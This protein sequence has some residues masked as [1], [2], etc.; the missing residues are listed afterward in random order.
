MLARK[1]VE[2]SPIAY[3]VDDAS[4]AVGIGQAKLWQLI[5][6]GKLAVVTLD[7]R[8][9]IMARDLEALLEEHRE[10]RGPVE[11]EGR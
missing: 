9:L 3:S 10:V 6:A 2:Y 8:T 4:V 11:G 5:S 1:K 7:R